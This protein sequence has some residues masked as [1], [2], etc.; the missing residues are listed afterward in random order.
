MAGE[1][2]DV[3]GLRD[4]VC[5]AGVAGN[6]G[7][8]G[9][10]HKR[11]EVVGGVVAIDVQGVHAAA[12][13]E[14][15]ADV[16][17]AA[18]I[19]LGLS[20][21]AVGVV[22]HALAHHRDGSVQLAPHGVKS[23]ALP[24][25]ELSGCAQVA[26]VPARLEEGCSL[27][28]A[29]LELDALAAVAQGVDATET[30]GARA[31]GGGGG[32]KDIGEQQGLWHLEQL[33]GARVGHL[34]PLHVEPAA[35]LGVE[36]GDLGGVQGAGGQVVGL[37]RHKLVEAHVHA[38]IGVV[39]GH[40]VGHDI[41]QLEGHAA[42]GVVLEQGHAA[43]VLHLGLVRETVPVGL[44]QLLGQGVIGGEVGAIVALLLDHV[45]VGSGNLSRC[46]GPLQPA[47]VGVC[48]L[49]AQARAVGGDGAGAQVHEAAPRIT[50]HGLAVNG[51]QLAG[52]GLLDREH[53]QD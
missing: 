53:I 8:W 4:T 26:G 3:V 37:V 48:L 52:A 30:L 28:L 44:V 5:C 20:S 27:L 45:A 38:V 13:V 1:E 43:V 7:V 14:G 2:R 49:A 12:A 19:E 9:T 33:L 51:A 16:V 31:V 11:V 35:I 50:G 40:A 18:H 34:D 21:A 25:G 23:H 10:T 46:L 39:N 22:L 41:S 24:L 47:S 6:G 15:Q 29:I 36:L 32:L 42:Q 17:G